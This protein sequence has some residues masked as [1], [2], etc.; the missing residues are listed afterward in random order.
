MIYSLSEHS[1]AHVQSLWERKTKPLSIRGRAQYV[2]LCLDRT[3][4]PPSAVGHQKA[5][6]L[7]SV[8]APSEGETSEEGGGDR[9]ALTLGGLFK[10]GYVHSHLK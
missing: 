2:C 6:S 10:L 8:T 4:H 5:R 7:S 1:W 3:A 9:S